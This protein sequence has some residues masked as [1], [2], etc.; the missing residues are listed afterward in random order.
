MGT[1]F[2]LILHCELNKGSVLKALNHWSPV[3]AL[4]AIVMHFALD[5]VV[6]APD[7]EP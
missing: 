7:S 1:W 4:F 3:H 2:E 5:A 6:V